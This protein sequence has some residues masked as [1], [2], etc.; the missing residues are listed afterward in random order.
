MRERIR[1][2]H[3]PSGIGE[4]S[5]AE[6]GAGADCSV[7][8]DTGWVTDVAADDMVVTPNDYQLY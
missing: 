4:F 7:Y 3:I 1:T 2:I 8:A 6:F 5:V